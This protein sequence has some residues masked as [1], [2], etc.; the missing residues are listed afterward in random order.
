M[1]NIVKRETGTKCHPDTMFS[2]LEKND[3]VINPNHA[4]DA[5]RYYFLELVEKLKLQDDQVDS[6]IMY[7]VNHDSNHYLIMT[8]FQSNRRN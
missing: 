1:W 5:S 4:A 8:L 7:L 2:E 6:A 3:L